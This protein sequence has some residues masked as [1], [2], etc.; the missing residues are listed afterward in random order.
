MKKIF[1]LRIKRNFSLQIIIFLSFSVL[2]AVVLLLTAFMINTI[3][4]NSSTET[5]RETSKREIALI[6]NNLDSKLSHI[7]DYA[8]SVAINTNVIQTLESYPSPPEDNRV[9]D[10]VKEVLNDAVSTIMGLNRNIYLWDIVSTN[11]EFFRVGVG[12]SSKIQEVLP[13]G[14]FA[15]LPKDFGVQISGPYL[16]KDFEY[17]SGKI[18]PMFIITKRIVDLE[19][20]SP[21][22]YVFFAIQEQ[23]FSSIF[24]NNMPLSEDSNYFILDE[25]NRV[26]SSSLKSDITKTAAE[27]FP[28]TG[29]E[30]NRLYEKKSLIVSKNN[31]QTVYSLSENLAD[32]VNWKVISEVS[33]ESLLAEQ[34]NMSRMIMLIGGSA[35]LIAFIIAFLLSVSVSR[36]IQEL[37]RTMRGVTE[38]N[39]TAIERRRVPGEMETLYSGYNQLMDTVNGLLQRVYTEERQKSEYQFRLLQAQIKP[40]FLYNTLETIK[41]LI[42]LNMNDT[43]AKCL[44]AMATFYRLSLSSGSEIIPVGDEV[45]L[46]Q[47][48]MY[49]QKLRYIE[50]LDYS[51]DIPEALTKYLIPKMTLQPILE[52]AIYHGIKERERMGLI[53]VTL[54]EH[55]DRLMFR[56]TDNGAGMSPEAL[57][58][59]TAAIAAGTHTDAESAAEPTAKSGSFGLS[60]IHRRLRIL[61]GEPYGVTVE[62]RPDAFTTVTVTIPK[63]AYLA[64]N[65]E[66]RRPALDEKAHS[67]H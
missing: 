51:F 11:G 15:A 31:V 29:Q 47:Q 45:R 50:H 27:V 63:V 22:G 19:T 65:Q 40:H 54:S 5:A 62:S 44:T 33:L 43:A 36:P 16:V 57:A 4:R 59:L 42:E 20:R 55:S 46:S 9:K 56:I 41:S 8:I 32:T 37:A 13:A 30:L 38:K 17:L 3:T 58:A 67:D 1:S 28:L 64:G 23:S 26:V 25:N 7:E 14:F 66:E 6:T 12:N 18:T 34:N 2:I 35:L 24:Q 53:S 61:Y 21:R 48:Y 60:S 10:Q 49:I 52:N 39:M